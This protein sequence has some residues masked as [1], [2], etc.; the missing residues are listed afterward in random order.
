MKLHSLLVA[1]VLAAGPA[2]ADGNFA[3][4]LGGGTTGGVVEGQ[5]RLNDFLQL[6]GG[7]NYLSI[8]A[9]V[10]EDDINYD[11]D[12]ELSGGGAF[13]D[14]HPFRNSFMLSA[15]VLVGD[16]TFDFAA[17]S[18]QAVSIGDIVFTPAEYG[19][20]EGDTSWNDAA[21]FVGLGFDN[22]FSGSGN[23]GFSAVLGAA[24]LG[25]GEVVLRSVGG[26]LS[27][28][29]ILREQLDIEAARLEEEIEDY[30]YYPVAQVGLSY[31]F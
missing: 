26:T 30:E 8:G 9:D 1:G 3:V 21:P 15:G 27:D 17:T 11:G 16:K 10:T 4:T 13:V 28:D 25:S 12:F 18:D 5:V 6:R 31:R 20:L 14:L 29:P 22:T 23:W 2:A 24:F 7:G 19:R